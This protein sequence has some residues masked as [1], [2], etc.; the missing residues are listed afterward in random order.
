MFVRLR[1]FIL[2]ALA[3]LLLV[4]S[5]IRRARDLRVRLDAEGV[6]SIA[7]S[8]GADMTERAGRWLQDGANRTSAD[9]DDPGLASSDE[10]G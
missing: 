4:A 5:A 1:W 8:Y 6:R 7:V 9:A 3:M 10:D 2:G